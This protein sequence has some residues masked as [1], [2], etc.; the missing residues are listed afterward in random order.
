MDFNQ[1]KRKTCRYCDTP[2][3]APFLDLGI[4]P[5][6]NNLPRREDAGKPEFHC[7]LAVV[8]CPKCHL[9]QLTHSVPGHL[10]FDEYL[11][12]SSTTQTFRT[13]FAGYAA[14]VRARLSGKDRPLGV[15]IGSNDGLLVSCYEKAGMRGVGIEPAKNLAAEANRQGVTTLNR[16]FGEDSV[17][18]VI[19]KYGKA[20]AISANNVFAHIDDIQSVARNVREL[21]ADDGFFVIEFAYLVTMLEKMFFDMVYHEHVCYIGVTALGFLVGRFGMEIFDVKEV[22]THGGSLRVFMQKK[23]GPRGRTP[24]V[25]RFLALEKERGCLDEKVYREFGA[26]VM[27]FKQNLNGMIADLRK[28]GKTISGYGA[29]AKASTIINFCE[30]TPDQIVYI[31]DDNPLKQ[32]RLVPGR[33]IP[34]V[35]SA[36]L[37]AHPTDYVL[38][39]A[40][41]F[42]KEIIAKIE[43]LRAKGVR[44]IIPL[45]EPVLA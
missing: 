12:V 14:D 32:D 31:V 29:P 39:F 13:H 16:Y 11:Y 41:N 40:W 7:P 37:N 23:G 17:R 34:I 21:L 20:D 45:P 5:L 44:F 19:A 22:D 18:E 33:K 42:A 24:A 15:D 4:Q 25:D 10:M 3:G 2:L 36:H 6:A 9:V 27:G 30:L 28:Q 26:R 43:P 38:I 8:K 1:Y 35:P